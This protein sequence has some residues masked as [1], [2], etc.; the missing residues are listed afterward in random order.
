M[1]AGTDE[2]KV[3]KIERNQPKYSKEQA[4]KSEKYRQFKDALGVVL[5]EGRNYTKSEIE[6]ALKLFYERKVR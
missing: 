3:E 5:D 1:D 6:N 2:K 4:L